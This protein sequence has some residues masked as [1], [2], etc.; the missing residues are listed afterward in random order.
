MRISI[1]S[2]RQESKAI[3][4]YCIFS[5][6]TALSTTNAEIFSTS[7]SPAELKSEPDGA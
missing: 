7:E 5:S 4:K 3:E 6:R 1:F 2:L